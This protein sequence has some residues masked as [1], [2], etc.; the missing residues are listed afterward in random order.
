MHFPLSTILATSSSLIFC[1]FLSF[2][3]KYFLISVVSP[4]FSNGLFG[5]ILLSFQV[6]S[7]LKK[8]YLILLNF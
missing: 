1:V 8:I 3:L 4:L 7:N 5:N 2:N 6:F